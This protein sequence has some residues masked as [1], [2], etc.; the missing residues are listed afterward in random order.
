MADSDRN[1][2]FKQY[3]DSICLSCLLYM[4]RENVHKNASMTL[5]IWH[6]G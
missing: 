3:N 4:P 1:R 5:V 2:N 6:S